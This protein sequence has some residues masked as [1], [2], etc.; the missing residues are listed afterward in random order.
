MR[1]TLAA[2]S[3]LALTLVSAGASSAY[4]CSEEEL[5]AKSISLSELVKAIVDKD[6]AQARDWKTKQVAVDRFA[7]VT[8]DL[9]KICAEYDKV[10]AEAQAAQ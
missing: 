2:V 1:R 5:Q 10:I 9:D 8:T 3:F 7:E 6:P 4:A